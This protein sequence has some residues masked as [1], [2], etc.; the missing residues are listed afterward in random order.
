MKLTYSKDV[1]DINSVLIKNIPYIISVPLSILYNKC[2]NKGYFT[3]SLKIAKVI[4]IYKKGIQDN[5]ENY[6]PIS[7]LPILSKIFDKLIKTRIS[8]F[9]ENNN[10]INNRKF[11]FRNNLSTIDAVNALIEEVTDNLD[12]RLKYSMLSL[13][14]SKA[15][16]I[17]DHNILINKLRNIGVRGV[18][19]KLMKSYLFNR[20]QL[21]I[22]NNSIS[23]LLSIQFGVPKGSVLGPLLFIIYIN[24]ISY[25]DKDLSSI[26]F[27]D[28]TSFIFKADML[29][30]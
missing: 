20:K 18:C 12:S 10:I 11:G 8:L 19:L 3:D 24:D 21:V 7:I 2:F 16:D 6:R 22:F 4:P 26:I 15:F 5:I 27:E 13:D 14:V 17:I 29:Y 1:Y 25:I 28:D 30:S 9:I 23:S